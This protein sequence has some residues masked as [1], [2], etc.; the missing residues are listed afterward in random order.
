M[1]F[2]NLGCPRMAFGNL[3]CPQ[4][5]THTEGRSYLCG[6]Q[7]SW[8]IHPEVQAVGFEGPSSLS[9]C[10]GA[11]WGCVI[12]GSWL[13][14]GC[15]RSAV[16]GRAGG[17]WDGCWSPPRGGNHPQNPLAPQSALARGLG[18]DGAPSLALL[19]PW[20]GVD[21]VSWGGG[22]HLPPPPPP[23]QPLT[24]QALNFIPLSDSQASPPDYS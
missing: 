20:P 12:W 11:A 23:S 15:L 19:Q 6:F 4:A 24:S 22:C 16:L 10:F 2:G 5:G 21:A 8:F 13:C 1:A 17:R 3:G 18:G 7:L 9:G 14:W